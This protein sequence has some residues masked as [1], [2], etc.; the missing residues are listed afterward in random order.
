MARKQTVQKSYHLHVY[1][2]RVYSF[3]AF[4]NKLKDLKKEVKDLEFRVEQLKE[5][6]EALEALRQMLNHSSFFLK[7]IQN[8]S[9]LE[10]EDD[11]IFTKVEVETLEKLVNDTQVSGA[12]VTHVLLGPRREKTC[13]QGFRQRD[14]QTS[15]LSYR[16]LKFC[17]W[18][19]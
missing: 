17:L 18:Q 16:V 10:L 4:I 5:R 8:L 6:P 12:I 1:N 14:T 19:A 11:P 2:K 15:L 3:Q 9:A 13:L 7:S